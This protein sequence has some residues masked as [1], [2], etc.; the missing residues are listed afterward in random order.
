M[1]YNTTNE[2]KPELVE[3]WC[4]TA[5][6]D[7][8]VMDIFLNNPNQIFNPFEVQEHIIN[9]FG[10]NFPITSIR[11]SINTLTKDNILVKT[12]EKKKGK[13]GKS[14]YCWTLATD[15]F[16]LLETASFL[17]NKEDI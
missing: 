2:K 6:Q 1:F 7:T 8:L 10:R 16:A 11:R 5:K 17:C 14:N 15:N 3:A 12:D 4:R 13:Y 9:K